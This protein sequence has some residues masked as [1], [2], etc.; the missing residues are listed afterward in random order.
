MKTILKQIC[1]TFLEFS[2][3]WTTSRFDAAFLKFPS[4]REIW[5]S[6]YL[7]ILFGQV[8]VFVFHFLDNNTL[9]LSAILIIPIIKLLISCIFMNT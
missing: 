9:V 5:L 4:L 2:L 7:E 3:S 8:L 6:K 1:G